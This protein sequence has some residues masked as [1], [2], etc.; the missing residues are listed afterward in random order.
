MAPEDIMEN[1]IT[2]SK[3]A[4]TYLDKGDAE[5]AEKILEILKKKKLPLN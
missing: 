2:L 4:Y 3:K 5:S 1:N